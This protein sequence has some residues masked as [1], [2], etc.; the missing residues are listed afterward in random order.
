M[1]FTPAEDDEMKKMVL[2]S[3]TGGTKEGYE[4]EVRKWKEF[5]LTIDE[6]RRP[7]EYLRGVESGEEKSK[8]VILFV[9]YLYTIIGVRGSKEVGRIISALRFQWNVQGLETGFF[10]SSVLT[11]AKRGA[12]RTPDEAR[13]EGER[14]E[15]MRI[16]PICL[17]IVRSMRN[18]LFVMSGVDGYGLYQK[19]LWIS[20][21][22]GFDSGLRPCNITLKNGKRAQDHCIRASHCRYLIEGEER[23]FTGGEQIRNF[24]APDYT[25]N[26]KRV[27]K[28]DVYVLTG[29]TINRS[30]FS[31]EPKSIGRG[32]AFEAQLLEDLCWFNLHSGVLGTDEFIAR[33]WLG[34]RK[35]VIA[36]DLADELK[37]EC[38]LHGLPKAK[39]SC[40]SLRSGYATHMNACKVPREEMVMRGGWSE[41][42]PVP[43][44]HYIRSFGSGA[45]GSS[46]SKGGEQDGIGVAE[47]KRLLPAS[48]IGRL[49]V[50][51]RASV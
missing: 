27:V 20:S 51:R 40:K 47:I 13:T 15:E 9:A 18:R 2:R 31:A 39:F 11:A 24:L 19:A 6:W 44:N 14:V 43:E 41:K 10:D 48:M 22:V 5:L 25:N 32:T 30:C 26:V 45:L 33:Y 4:G 34:S 29:K 42:S 37:K 50:D 3:V 1:R 46:V 12:R 38:A 16:L 17:E 7:D 23:S 35:V 8:W 36:K 49:L 28:V 21:G